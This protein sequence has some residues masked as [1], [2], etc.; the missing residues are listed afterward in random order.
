M[1]WFRRLF[2]KKPKKSKPVEVKQES[3]ASQAGGGDSRTD[4]AQLYLQKVNEKIQKLGVD[5]AGGR[6]NRAQFQEL[7]G[8]YQREIRS[9]EGFLVVDPD[10]W[11]DGVK[12]G[13]STFIKRQ[14]MARAKAYAIYENGSGMPVATLGEF[15]RDPALV[16]PMLS[17]FRSAT[18]EL[19]GG[20]MKTTELGNEGWLVF[21][22]GRYT[23]MIALFTN[24]PAGVQLKFMDE[25]HQ[26]FEQANVKVLSLR[27]IETDH[28]IFP[29]EYYLGNWKK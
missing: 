16:I 14:H 5:F 23:T 29:H 4:H 20:G 19:F 3:A 27:P 7:Y 6:I 10:A 21:V 28:L 11:T 24:E 1:N 22:P 8:H 17:S 25:L 9:I 12:E 13:A 18:G 2:A 15:V 26:L